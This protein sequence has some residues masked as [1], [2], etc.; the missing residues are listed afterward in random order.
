MNIGKDAVQIGVVTYGQTGADQFYL[1][2]YLLRATILQKISSLNSIQLTTLNYLA[3]G[4]N[5]VHLQQF[6]SSKG[7]RSN[8]QNVVV[9]LTTVQSDDT[10]SNISAQANLLKNA[11]TRIYSIGLNSASLTEMAGISSSPQIL[12]NDYFIIPEERQLNDFADIFYN[13]IC[14]AN[15]CPGRLLLKK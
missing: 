3:N 2:D 14:S 4:L 13:I 9:V 8:V 1:Q 12:N 10:I 11:G 5:E 15:V 6:V 7:D